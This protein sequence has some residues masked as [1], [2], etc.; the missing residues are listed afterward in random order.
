[1]KYIVDVLQ[2]CC[3]NIQTCVQFKMGVNHS[4]SSLPFAETIGVYTKGGPEI[5]YVSLYM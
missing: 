1:M 5:T 2:L 3:R 4:L